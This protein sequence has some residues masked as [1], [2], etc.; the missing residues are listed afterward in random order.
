MMTH[1]SKSKDSNQKLIVDKEGHFCDIPESDLRFHLSK[2]D[3]K[4]L[5]CPMEVA[6][7]LRVSRRTVERLCHDG[8]LLYLKVNR[9]LRVT[10]AALLHFIEANEVGV[11]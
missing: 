8:K 9:A 10:V 11:Q 1:H 2:F 3:R 6:Y 5:L 4:T 7:I